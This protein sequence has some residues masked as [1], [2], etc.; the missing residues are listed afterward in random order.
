MNKVGAVYFVIIP[1]MKE[2]ILNINNKEI[3]LVASE[4]LE[5]PFSKNIY[6]MIQ[7]DE[8]GEQEIPSFTEVY[9]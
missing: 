7:L 4:S 1:P 2:K 8:L 9:I 3:H 6:F 5:D